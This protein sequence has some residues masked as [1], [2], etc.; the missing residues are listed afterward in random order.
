[1]ARLW[2]E[3]KSDLRKGTGK[4]A[5]ENA[6]ATIYWGSAGDSKVAGRVQVR[7]PKDSEYPQV[8]FTFGEN[9]NPLP[10]VN[11]ESFEYIL[12]DQRKQNAG[13]SD[14]VRDNA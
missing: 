9:N 1:M 14:A 11:Y 5:S 8:Y 3:T 13:C 10:G 4:G 12:E 2:I 6:E 7:W